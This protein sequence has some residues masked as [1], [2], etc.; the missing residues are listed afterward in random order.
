M[1]QTKHGKK[2]T[3]SLV[4]L[5]SNIM[6]MDLKHLLKKKLNRSTWQN[7]GKPFKEAN[8]ISLNATNLVALQCGELKIEIKKTKDFS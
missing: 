8:K 4:T 1:T 3:G 2:L 7:G 5:S 6:V